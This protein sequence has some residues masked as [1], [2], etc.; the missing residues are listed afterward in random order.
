MRDLLLSAILSVLMLAA[1]SAIAAP[2][3]TKGH[4]PPGHPT[5][6]E[7]QQKMGIRNQANLP[8]Q[9]RVIESIAG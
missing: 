4:P 9:G 7:A 2:A 1:T 5:V 6:G 8:Y 3:K